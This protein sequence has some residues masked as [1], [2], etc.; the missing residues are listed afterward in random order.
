MSDIDFFSQSSAQLNYQPE[1]NTQS[2]NNCP[3]SVL[4]G[5]E[6]CFNETPTQWVWHFVPLYKPSQIEG[7]TN[8]WQVGFD[9]QKYL[10][11]IW[12]FTDGKQ[13]TEPNRKEI[14]P[15]VNRNMFEQSLQEIRTAYTNKYR[16]GYRPA[17]EVFQGFEFQLANKYNRPDATDE[18]TGK[19]A[20]QNCKIFPVLVQGKLDGHRAGAKMEST[21]V[22]MFKR[23]TLR[24]TYFS[25]VKSELKNFFMLLPPG[26]IIDGEVW[27]PNDPDD[28]EAFQ[29]LTSAIK[30]EEYEHPDLKDVKYYIFDIC[31]QEMYTTEQRYY[32]LLH[33]YLQ[34]VQMYGEPK[35]F[36]IVSGFLAFSHQDL[37]EIHEYFTDELGLEGIMIR[38]IAGNSNKESWLKQTWYKGN[39]NNNL[40]K[41]KKFIDEEGTISEV[42]SAGGR[43]EGCAIFTIL[44]DQG[45]IFTVRPQG[46]FEIRRYW[47]QYPQTVIGKR[48]TYKYFTKGK[49]NVPRFPVG[50]SFR[51]DL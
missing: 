16:E 46:A 49:N 27:V 38:K 39:R 22:I 21:E 3:H 11:T 25:H 43:E 33:A 8:F 50:V 32:V 45:A 23:S 15:K 5:Q 19:Q 1:F 7:K 30:T 29:T 40:L 51:E 14:V 34:Y 41:Y 18:K 36:N 4:P 12:G 9:G 13:M 26:T 6:I 37:F 24:Y 44:S 2:F 42:H 20:S 35:N 47:L 28:P 31:L 10:L 48:Y 17:G